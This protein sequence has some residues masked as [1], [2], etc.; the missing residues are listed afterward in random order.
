[1]AL[2]PDL[3]IPGLGFCKRDEEDVRT[4]YNILIFIGEKQYRE[5]IEMKR[6]ALSPPAPK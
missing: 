2:S 3:D 5:F 1:M 4:A 6:K